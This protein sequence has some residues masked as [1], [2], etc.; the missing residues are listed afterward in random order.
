L[1][2]WVA[3]LSVNEISNWEICR[4]TN[5]FGSGASRAAGVRAGD[6]LYFWWAQHGL[7]ARAVATS[8]AQP[9]K[10]ENMVQVPW[11]SPERYK[12]LI[13]IR[14]LNDRGESPLELRWKELNDLAGIG[15]VPASQFP[16]V[17]VNRTHRLDVLFGDADSGEEPE[18]PEEVLGVDIPEGHDTRREAL[19]SLKLRRGQ[20][21]F[22]RHLLNAYG[23]RCVVS[24]CSVGHV[25]EAAHIAPYRGPHTN[26]PENGLLLRADVH[27]L[28]DLS[29]LTV[30]PDYE[31]RVAP[32]LA[33][34][35]YGDFDALHFPSASGLRP[36]RGLLERHNGTCSWL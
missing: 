26:R 31:V 36:D 14:V 16:P 9:V 29:L 5:L 11:P 20:R 22:R 7:F 13:P 10:H 30:T 15:G 3:S 34:T 1:A 8:D 12:Y 4:A 27:T 17:D 25:L 2:G 6:K 33:S 23:V 18:L 28:F 24:Q 32:H 21:E 35:L 19:V